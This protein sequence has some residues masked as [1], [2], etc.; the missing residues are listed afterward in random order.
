MNR[1]IQ[2]EGAS[3]V[4]KRAYGLRQFLLRGNKK[5]LAET[6]LPAMDNNN[7]QLH[8]K[9]QQ[10]QIDRHFK[11]LRLKNRKNQNIPCFW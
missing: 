6:L 7:N 4:I 2:S 8:N 3:G 5:I 11:N 10:N 1:S 9:I